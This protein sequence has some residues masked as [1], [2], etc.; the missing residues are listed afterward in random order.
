MLLEYF[1]SLM[2]LVL[3][4]M[5]TFAV[6]YLDDIIIFSPTLEEHLKHIEQ[7]FGRLIEHNLKLKM[8]KCKF[9]EAETQYLGFIVNKDGV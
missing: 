5:E 4:G 9:L 1:K 3:R 7:V 2:S 8:S 6:A